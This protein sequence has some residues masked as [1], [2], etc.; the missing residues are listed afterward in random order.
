MRL[1]LARPWLV[2]DLDRPRRTLGWAVNKPGF[3]TA[4]RVVWREVRDADLP[5]ELDVATWLTTE[6][7][8]A[9]F[10]DSPC[11]LTSAPLARHVATRASVGGITARV[12]ATVGLSN[13]ERVGQ[14]VAR[15]SSC[16][17]RAGTINLLVDIDAPLADGALVEALGIA[18]EART[19]AVVEGGLALA[20][21][22]AT[23][24]GTDCVIVAAPAGTIAHAGKHT[25]V[26]E[27]LG[28]AAFAA[29]SAGVADWLRSREKETRP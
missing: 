10:A 21:G 26:G 14:R 12:A 3:A 22:T 17:A 2:A 7:D 15:E 29:V 13:A 18:V 19:A 6:L 23:G 5:P 27:A 1:T 11:L 4:A 8:Q 9:G 25:A 20:A 24:T 28:R 16:P